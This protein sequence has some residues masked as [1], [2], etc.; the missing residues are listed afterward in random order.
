MAAGYSHSGSAFQGTQRGRG[1]CGAGQEAL[2][3][4]ELGRVSRV[5]TAL[6]MPSRC[7]SLLEPAHLLTCTQG[8]QGAHGPSSVTSEREHFT[9]SLRNAS[10]GN[11]AFSGVIK[12]SWH[13]NVPSVWYK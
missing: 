8:R 12:S 10:H 13:Y 6:Q 9:A 4:L 7:S 11:K 3:C 2:P 1:S 5:G